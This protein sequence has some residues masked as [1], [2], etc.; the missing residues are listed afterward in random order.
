MSPSNQQT[1]TTCP[2]HGPVHC[3]NTQ[4][5]PGRTG[6]A[7][8]LQPVN[9]IVHVPPMY[10]QHV[11]TAS[12][13]PSAAPVI[14]SPKL[15]WSLLYTASNTASSAISDNPWSRT[16]VLYYDS[17]CNPPALD[18]L[19]DVSLR[20][21]SLATEGNAFQTHNLDDHTSCFPLSSEP[22]YTAPDPELT[23]SPSSYSS[24][25]QWQDLV[26]SQ[27]PLSHPQEP[28]LIPIPNRPSAP[29]VICRWLYNGRRCGHETTLGEYKQHWKLNHFPECRDALI[30]CR[31]QD[32]DYHKRG[33]PSIRVMLRGCMWRHI[34]EV[35]LGHRRSTYTTTATLTS[36]C[37]I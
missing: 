23:Y 8:A 27:P 22:R 29:P 2:V 6:I 30:Q 28:Y 17:P 32:C 5:N 37:Y 11:G 26:I 15:V 36:L 18:D 4:Y 35:H 16:P 19:G 10:P 20:S 9:S 14:S 13:S 3:C 21:N 34:H 1:S 25:S 24:L 33:D 31:W 12:V 7:C